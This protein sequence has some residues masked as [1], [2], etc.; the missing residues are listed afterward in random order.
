LSVNPLTPTRPP[1]P[2]TTPISGTAL[3]PVGKRPAVQSLGGCVHWNKNCLPK[4]Q[5]MPA[6]NITDPTQPATLAD[7]CLESP[8]ARLALLDY[9]RLGPGR[10]LPTLLNRYRQLGPAAPTHAHGTLRNWSSKYDWPGRASAYDEIEDRRIQAEY[11]A[12]RDSILQ[13]GI[14]L[15]CERVERLTSLYQ[16]LAALVESDDALWTRNVRILHL[17]NDQVERVELRRFNGAIFSSLRA[18]L[19]DIAAETGGRINR[20]Q[21]PLE[22]GFAHLNPSDYSFD[23]FTPQEK[24]EFLRLQEIFLTY[25]TLKSSNR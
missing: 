20:H 7:G 15:D 3:L 13:R 16:K 23:C 10:T 24:D 6:W 17:G 11:S 18:I 19:A 14:A 4:E 12:R 22:P 1:N 21:P 5:K 8:R 25:P 9:L 2:N